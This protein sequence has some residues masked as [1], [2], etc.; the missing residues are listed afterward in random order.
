MGILLFIVA[1]MFFILLMPIGLLAGILLKLS[2][3]NSKAYDLAL[4]IDQL[5]NV[6]F[7]ELF[8]KIFVKGQYY[9]FGNPD[10]TISSVLGKNKKLNTLT[11]FGR[12]IDRF[13]S[14]LDRNHTIKSIEENP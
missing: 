2:E 10:E 11:S 12:L 3:T 4:C 13:L 9:A 1:S 8:N 6:M 14:K 7:Q 5:A